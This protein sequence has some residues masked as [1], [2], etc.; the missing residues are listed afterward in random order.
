MDA[1]AQRCLFSYILFFHILLIITILIIT[2]TNCKA[3][4]S[5]EECM[6]HLVSTTIPGAGNKELVRSMLVEPQ[7]LI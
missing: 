4:G 3:P 7:V 5:V 6:E 1:L 2:I